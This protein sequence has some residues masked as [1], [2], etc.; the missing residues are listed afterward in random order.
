MLR[1]RFERDSGATGSPHAPG[2]AARL[3]AAD[4]WHDALG[5]LA[6]ASTPAVFGQT[7]ARARGPALDTEHALRWIER[8]ED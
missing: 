1:E 6:R 4:L 3:V 8:V 5:V 2:L 7:L